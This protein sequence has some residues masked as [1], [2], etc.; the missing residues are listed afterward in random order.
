MVA[1]LFA[2]TGSKIE[3]TPV[4]ICMPLLYPPSGELG[5]SLI[6]ACTAEILGTC[7]KPLLECCCCCGIGGEADMDKSKPGCMVIGA[8]TMLEAV[9]TISDACPRGS[10]GT[11]GSLLYSGGM[12]LATATGV[13]VIVEAM[14]GATVVVLFVLITGSVTESFF[15]GTLGSVAF[16][17]A[18]MFT[19][20]S[21]GTTA[22]GATFLIGAAVAVAVGRAG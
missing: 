7:G 3:G 5:S 19:F 12:R 2:G 8:L 20:G 1:R 22:G 21:A 14:V 16:S 6:V 17:A 18:G 9:V 11:A 4:A 10:M 15:T 13:S